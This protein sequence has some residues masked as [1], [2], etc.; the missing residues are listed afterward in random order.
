MSVCNLASASSLPVILTT[1][2]NPGGPQAARP[3]STRLPVRD[4]K[5]L[6]DDEDIIVRLSHESMHHLCNLRSLEM[7]SRSSQSRRTRQRHSFLLVEGFLTGRPRG[8]FVASN[9]DVKF[10]IEVREGRG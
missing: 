2:S 5:G 10:E 8:E 6:T 9:V 3:I 1:S 7:D 4:E